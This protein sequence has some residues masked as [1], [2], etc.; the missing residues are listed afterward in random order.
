MADEA[1]KSIASIPSAVEEK[2]PIE[3]DSGMIVGNKIGSYE[4]SP[5]AP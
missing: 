5:E 2:P 4:W 1:E 3:E